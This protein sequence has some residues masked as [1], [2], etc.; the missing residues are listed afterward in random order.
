DLEVLKKL[1]EVVTAKLQGLQE[2]IA[3]LVGFEYWAMNLNSPKQVQQ[4]LFDKLQ[5]PKQKKSAKGTGYST[6]QEVLAVL[7]KMHPV[8]GLILQ[9]RELA[10]LKNTYI[11][12]LPAYVN[13]W[14]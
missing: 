5:L 12:A 8:P 13:K 6:D 1:D 11:D 7:S 14:T 3:S 2:G 9:Y 4:L 10:K